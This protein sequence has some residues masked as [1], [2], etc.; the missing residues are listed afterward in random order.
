VS[1]ATNFGLTGL[2]RPGNVDR[3]KNEI[4]SRSGLKKAGRHEVEIWSKVVGLVSEEGKQYPPTTGLFDRLFGGFH[5][6][7]NRIDL[8]QDL[9]IIKRQNPAP[10]V[11]VVVEEDT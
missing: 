5:G 11:R 9:R 8:R 2:A 3:P 10:I 1:L 6:H 7:E 4:W